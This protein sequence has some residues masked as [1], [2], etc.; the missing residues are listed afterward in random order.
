VI[1]SIARDPVATV[2]GRLRAYAELEDGRARERVRTR[3]AEL[4]SR[5]G[6]RER[7]ELYGAAP[8][9]AVSPAVGELLY[10]LTI[11]RRPL[12]AIEFGT[13]H[14][15]STI[16]LAAALCDAGAGGAVSAE[17]LPEKA[18]AARSNLA[19]AGL[20]G[21]VEIRTGDALETLRDVPGPVDLVFLDGR[22]DL[23]LD[24]LLL[25]EPALAA[26]ALVLADLSAGDPDLL[27]YLDHVRGEG[28]YRSQRLLGEAGLEVSV[29]TP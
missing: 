17:L 25:L 7:Y 6:T 12:S 19:A 23:Y 5:L 8:P 26:N 10:I 11:A 1:A 22:N 27:P 16:Y 29:R 24:V 13:S 3:E 2:L 18:E 9:L 21:V 28:S 4:G 20:A 14:G 15:I